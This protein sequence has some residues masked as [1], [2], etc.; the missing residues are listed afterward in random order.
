MNICWKIG[1]C[2][3]NS[4]SRVH[5]L[6][7]PETTETRP[8]SLTPIHPS[9]VPA[10]VR[11]TSERLE[12]NA[13]H[14]T[15]LDSKPSISALESDLTLRHTWVTHTGIDYRSISNTPPHTGDTHSQV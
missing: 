14:L 5:R 8:H 12:G 7:N 9:P 1:C 3:S 4:C 11:T 10:R 2:E 6:N 13:R 15:C